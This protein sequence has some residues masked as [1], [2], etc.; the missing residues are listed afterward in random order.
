MQWILVLYVLLYFVD[1]STID[2]DMLE[3]R[4][5]TISSENLEP[6]FK[7]MNKICRGS[8]EVLF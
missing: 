8:Q 7:A 4:L 2:I 6:E 3:I 5:F 1:I